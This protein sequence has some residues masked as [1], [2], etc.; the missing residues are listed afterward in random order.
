MPPCHWAM[1]LPRVMLRAKDASWLSQPG[2]SSCLTR[3][4]EKL[5]RERPVAIVQPGGQGGPG[6]VRKVPK[7]KHQK[8][9]HKKKKIKITK[10]TRGG[11]VV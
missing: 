6:R 11:G 1:R 8:D 5:D 4:K 10:F 7:F 3:K 2:S 9:T